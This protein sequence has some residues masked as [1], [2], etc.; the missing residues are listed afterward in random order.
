MFT[1]IIEAVSRIKTILPSEGKKLITIERPATFTDLKTGNS[2]A[3]DGICLTVT[4]FDPGTFSVEVMNETL[5]KSTAGVWLGGTLLNLERALRLGDRL[6]GHW[7]QGHIDHS[8][9]LLAR[10]RKGSTDYLRFGIGREDQTLVVPQGSIAVNGI[11][12]T[13]SELDSSGFSV[14]LIGHT[15]DNTNLKLLKPGDAVNLEFDVLAKYIKRLFE[16][17]KLSGE[18]LNEQGF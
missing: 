12:L 16:G 5:R 15:L 10:S 17:N 6:D 11:S 7:V 9:K 4:K 18:W 13:I 3:C 8:A 2:I 14:A 1:G